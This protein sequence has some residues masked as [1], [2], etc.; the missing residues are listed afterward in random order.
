LTLAGKNKKIV[1]LIFEFIVLEK[2]LWLTVYQLANGPVSQ[3]A[4]G[5]VTQAIVLMPVQPSRTLSKRSNP[6]TK[7]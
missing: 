5:V 3:N 7:P 1:G 6:A 4:T 2:L